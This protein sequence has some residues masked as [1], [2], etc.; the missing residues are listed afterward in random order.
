MELFG[1]D[2]YKADVEVIIIAIESLKHL[3]LENFQI[4][5][6]QTK[7]LRGILETMGVEEEIK[8]LIVQNME[9]K[10]LVALNNLIEQLSIEEDIKST[11]K[12]LPKLFGD[13]EEVLGEI[14]SLPLTPSMKEAVEELEMICKKVE[15]Y[16]LRE[17][18]KLDLGMITTLKYYSGVIFKGF[19][20]DLGKVL[21]SGGRYDELLRDFDMDIPA[22]GFAFSVNKV[23]KALK[24]QRNLE[25]QDKKHILLLEDENSGATSD[26]LNA[27]RQKGYIAEVNLLENKKDLKEYIKRRKID[28][29]IKVD[30]NANINTVGDLEG[31]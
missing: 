20:K 8:Q 31:I 1:I 21:L 10:N 14:N 28:E 15:E 25:V 9:D 24:I 11:L 4:D 22:T 19:T 26:V 2:S 18:I 13:P 6:G 3:G 29:I 12:Q 7:L 5:I 27:L 23:T 16:G 17:Y 30:E